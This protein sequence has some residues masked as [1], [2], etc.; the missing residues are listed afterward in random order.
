MGKKK[1]PLSN[2]PSSQWLKKVKKRKSQKAASEEERIKRA[3][4]ANDATGT[5]RPVGKGEKSSG[6]LHSRADAYKQGLPMQGGAPGSGK[7]R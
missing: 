1:G 6:T 3:Q 5:S 2:L 4:K 7:G